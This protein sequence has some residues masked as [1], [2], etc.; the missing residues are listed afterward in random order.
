MGRLGKACQPVFE[1]LG[2]DWKAGVSLLSGVA[3]KE[4]I[5]STIGVL[6]AEEG[7]TGAL[8]EKLTAS[9]DFNL[10]SALSFLVFVLLYFPCMATIAAIAS[11]AGWRWA[12]GALL[13]NTLVAWGV[14]WLFYQIGCLLI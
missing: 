10:A 7:E 6:Y 13:Y 8:A 14:A 11:E 4:I 1:P 5:V 3:A 2:L 9:G 12:L